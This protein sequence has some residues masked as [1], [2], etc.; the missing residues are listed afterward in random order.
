MGWARHL[1]L[2]GEV[3]EV[4]GR[5][6]GCAAWVWLILCLVF[7]LYAVTKLAFAYQQRRSPPQSVTFISAEESS[8]LDVFP[9][10]VGDRRHIYR[11]RQIDRQRDR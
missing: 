5:D 6:Q 1:W 10:V 3:R 9:N 7:I 2:H 4:D 8:D 11:D